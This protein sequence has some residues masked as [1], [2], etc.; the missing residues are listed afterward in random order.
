M[1]TAGFQGYLTGIR[2]TRVAAVQRD[3]PQ[4]HSVWLDGERLGSART[5]SIRVEPDALRIVV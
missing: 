2:M 5:V 3:V 1:G 4:G